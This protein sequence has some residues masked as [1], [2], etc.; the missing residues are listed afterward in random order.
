MLL[1][2]AERSH[3]K[4]VCSSWGSHG[5]DRDFSFTR[6]KKRMDLVI[7][8]NHQ[9]SMA[10]CIYCVWWVRWWACTWLKRT[11]AMFS[12]S[13]GFDTGLFTI[14][15]DRSRFPLGSYRWF[16]SVR[17][18][19]I[20]NRRPLMKWIRFLAKNIKIWLQDDQ[21]QKPLA[22]VTD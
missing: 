7:R 13:T 18:K 21:Y 19:T 1:Y 22:A 3:Y 4:Q 9:A 11:F 6:F 14:G 17:A 16:Q 8:Y 20:V 12:R 10:L 5:V 15:T 2:A